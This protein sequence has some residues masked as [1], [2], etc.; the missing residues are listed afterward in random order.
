M[1][2]HQ[3]NTKSKLKIQFTIFKLSEK[4]FDIGNKVYYLIIERLME[5][6]V[7]KDCN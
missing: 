6:V 3:K 4:R 5:T 2:I 1:M 7:R